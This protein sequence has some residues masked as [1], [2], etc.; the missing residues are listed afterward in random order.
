MSIVIECLFPPN[1]TPYVSQFRPNV[2]PF[3]RRH[4]ILLVKPRPLYGNV[5]RKRPELVEEKL[6]L[7]RA[8]CH[9]AT[10]C[11]YLLCKIVRV[12]SVGYR[13]GDLGP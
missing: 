1:A 8:L 13:G 7:C 11:A 10:S 2:S 12:G 5:P 3:R 6:P 4:A 9:L